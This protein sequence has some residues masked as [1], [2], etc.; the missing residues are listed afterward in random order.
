MFNLT[1]MDRERADFERTL[2]ALQKSFGR[3]VLPV[4]IPIG[5]EQGFNGVVD[6]VQRK[7]YRFTRDGN[8]KAEPADI[9]AELAEEV[10][11]PAQPPHRG[12]GRD[13][14][15]LMEGFFET[16]TLSQEDL[17]SGPAPRRPAA[18]RSSR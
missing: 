16:G 9:P 17:E 14:R 1:K 5:S 4:Q 15:P 7:A 11:D 18:A 6:L 8:G 3:G 10:D 2:E 13:R 12:R